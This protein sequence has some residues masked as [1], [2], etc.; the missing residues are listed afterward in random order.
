MLFRSP[1]G[2]I[3]KPLIQL[4][5]HTEQLSMQEEYYIYHL[6]EDLKVYEILLKGINLQKQKEGIGLLR[7]QKLLFYYTLMLKAF[8]KG[9][10]NTGFKFFNSLFH[11]DNF[12]ILSWLY[13]KKKV[14]K[15][16]NYQDVV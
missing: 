14:L 6:K 9:E 2:F 12:F 7:N 8:F 13:F 16:S 4:R 3:K 5:S 15:I 10:F 1:V 11:F